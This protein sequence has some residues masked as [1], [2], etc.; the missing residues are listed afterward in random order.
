MLHFRVMRRS[1]ATLGTPCG[2]T[3]NLISIKWVDS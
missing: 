3:S 1:D 2:K